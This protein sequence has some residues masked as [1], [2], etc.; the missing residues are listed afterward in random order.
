[1]HSLI[2]D[3]RFS[4]RRLRKSPG[5]AL[6]AILTLALGVGAN[7]VVFSVLNALVLR[8]LN[9]PRARSV[10]Q[11]SRGHAGW[12]SQSYPDYADYRDRNTTFSNIAAYAFCGAGVTIPAS[13]SQQGSVTQ[14]WGLEASGNYF[15]MLGIQPALGRFYHA[16]DERGPNSAPY[17]VVS[18]G[19]WHDRLN[20]DPH[21]IGSVINLNKHPYTI[22]GVAPASFHGTELMW[23]PNFWIPMVNEQDLEGSDYLKLR[24]DHQIEIV[25]RLKAGVTPRQGVDNL[26]TIARQLAKIHVEDEN[27]DAR[28]VQPGLLGD[29][30]GAPARAFLSGIMLM[31][32]LVLLAACANLASIFAARAADRGR[33]LSI[34]LAVGSS[35]WHTIR[36]LLTEAIIVALLG[37]AAGTVLAASLLQA[38]S[39]WQPLQ[40]VPVHVI[41]SPDP[42]VYA[43]ALILSLASGVFFGLLPARQIWKIDAAQAM[44]TGPVTIT[45]FRRFTLRDVLLAIQIAICT[46]LVTA[47]LVALRGMQRSLH[48]NLGFNPQG[49]TLLDSDFG[50]AGYTNDQSVPLEKRLI[51][52]A[53]K[54]P[55]V[56]AVGSINSIP[57]GINSSDSP[58]FLP[59]ATDLRDSNSLADA[60]YYIASPGYFRAAETHLLAGRDFTWHDDKNAP[61]VAI[62]NATF[63]RTMFG[64][65]SAIGQRFKR[66]N[67][68]IYEIVGVV[69]DGKYFNLAEEQKAAMFFPQAQDTHSEFFLVIRSQA[70]R[71]DVAPSL[72]RIVAG[73]DPGLPY[74]IHSWPQM[75]EFALFPSRA[76]TAALGLM[77]LLAAMLAVTGIFGM[78]SYSVSKRLKELGIRVALGAQ[79]AQLMR[80]AL[81][82]PVMLLLGGSVAGLILGV[83]ASGLLAHV[84]YQATPHDPLVLLGVVL[85]MMLLGTM[86]TLVPAR[87]AQSVD[88]ARLLR[89]D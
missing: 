77:G 41:V 50:L 14:V 46:L 47:S 75:L 45:V 73:I 80:A 62:V 20:G 2:Q 86:A 44:K 52:E 13:S 48:A 7:V 16:S 64:N 27:L 39:S 22:I 70:L 25:G 42:L 66:G 61:L 54:I 28:L 63:A 81:A 78:A 53:A 36:Q 15:D 85:T 38:L 3:I 72:Q 21:A 40:Q 12:D 84:V 49:V 68:T 60:M 76:A 29:G 31:A 65:K 32:L 79:P 89:E 56:L 17:V 88:P 74:H 43:V 83:M 51:D 82:R 35:R 8:P 71:T 67:K 1:M 10:Y 23:W 59:D 87:R 34:R 6:T 33:E 5:F 19:F 30:F 37:G 11:I 58:V 57:L 9:I 69:E 18:Y 4:L 24:G 26:T 55:G